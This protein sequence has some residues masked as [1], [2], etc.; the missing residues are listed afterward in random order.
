MGRVPEGFTPVESSAMRSYKYDPQANELHIQTNNPKVT[1]VY[2]DVQPEQARTF[3]NAGSKG[4][5]WNQLRQTSPLVA[6]IVN[7]KRIPVKVT[8]A[9]VTPK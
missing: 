7:G 3:T 4:K 9:G 1:Y 2:G 8:E 5:A 6:K